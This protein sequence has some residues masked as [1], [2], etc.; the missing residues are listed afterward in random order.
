MSKTSKTSKTSKASKA[1]QSSVSRAIQVKALQLRDTL[2]RSIE[3]SR[4]HNLEYCCF[5]RDQGELLLQLLDDLLKEI[6]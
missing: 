6:Q 1:S 3:W 2:A 4:A 5:K